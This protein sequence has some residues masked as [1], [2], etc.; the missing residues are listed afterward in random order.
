MT[1][2]SKPRPHTEPLPGE[3]GQTTPST[4]MEHGDRA[5]RVRWTGKSTAVGFGGR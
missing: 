3:Y 2:C 1:A 4:R 5:L